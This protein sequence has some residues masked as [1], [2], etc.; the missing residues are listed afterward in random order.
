MN[1]KDII[2]TIEK[3]ECTIDERDDRRWY[4][5][6]MVRGLDRRSLKTWTGCGDETG[7]SPTI[8]LKGAIESAMSAL[9]KQWRKENQK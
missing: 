8:A 9:R 4:A 1:K 5:A 6:V 3:S 2:Y 7:A